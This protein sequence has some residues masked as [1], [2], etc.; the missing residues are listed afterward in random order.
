MVRSSDNGLC[1]MFMARACA[2]L[3]GGG[4]GRALMG[5]ESGHGVG[6]DEGGIL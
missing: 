2:S 5:R 4:G 6:G 3:R 1:K